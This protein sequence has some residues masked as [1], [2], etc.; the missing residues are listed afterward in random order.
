[1][2]IKEMIQE[3][4]FEY[5][6]DTK[7]L[8]T[9]TKESTKVQKKLFRLGIKWAGDRDADDVVNEDTYLLFIEDEKLYFVEDISYWMKNESRR[10]E[11]S[12]ILAIQ[13]KEEKPKF[14]P[15]TL[16]PFDKVLVR[17]YKDGFWRCNLFS[18]IIEEEDYRFECILNYW[19]YCIP[20][21]E[22]TKHLLDT[23]EEE[24]EYYQVCER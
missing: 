4:I 7:I 24:P 13:L 23:Q 10:I 14:D 2:E 15:K 8:C 21:N 9:S 19:N 5:L 11:P 18:H 1:M 20:F 17:D 22:E 3:E 12:E 6:N 16:K